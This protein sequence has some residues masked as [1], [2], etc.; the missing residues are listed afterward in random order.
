MD[1]V[2]I[3]A[4]PREVCGSRA[5]RRLRREDLVPAVIY[6]RDA[7]NVVLSI[8]RS[9]LEHLVR[10]RTFIVS[11]SWDGQRENAQI[12]EIQYDALGDD[13]IHVDLVRISLSEVVT[14]SVSIEIHGEAAGIAE[15]GA[16]DQVLHEL[17]VECLPTA[18][19]ENL[20]VEVAGLAIGDTLRVAD[21]K[22]PEGA[23]ALDDPETVVVTVV[24]PQELAEEEDALLGEEAMAEPEVIGR[25]A[26]QGG[27]PDE[28]A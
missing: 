18:V 21:I 11:V 12:T 6:G 25:E 26:A 23:R 20:R 3:E 2:E 1:I 27:E 10:E 7:P 9:D 22:L 19:P 16:L 15:G 17:E 28:G 24:A 14:V 8:T 13:I 4:R 5:C